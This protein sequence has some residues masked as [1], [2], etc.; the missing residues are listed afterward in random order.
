MWSGHRDI[1]SWIQYI[2]ILKNGQCH[3]LSTKLQFFNYRRMKCFQKDKS[4]YPTGTS[5]QLVGISCQFYILLGLANDLM[6]SSFDWIDKR[7]EPMLPDELSARNVAI[8]A[9]IAV[10]NETIELDSAQN[11]FITAVG[12]RVEIKT[13]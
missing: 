4:K 9:D 11:A 3:Y 6:S 2:V 8:I 12:N 10:D 7:V 13:I 1:M 5:S